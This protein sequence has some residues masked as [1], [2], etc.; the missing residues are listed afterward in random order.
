M[1]ARG[2]RHFKLTKGCKEKAIQKKD[3]PQNIRTQE[4][5]VSGRIDTLLGYSDTIFLS[6]SS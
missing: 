6:F 5:R 4:F 2:K 3:Y 1:G